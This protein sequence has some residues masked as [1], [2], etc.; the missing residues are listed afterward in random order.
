MDSIQTIDR[1]ELL[2]DIERIVLKIGTSSLTREDGSFNRGLTEDIAN[3]VAKL[4]ELGKTVIIISS[5]A[6]GIGCEE[7]KMASRPR[8][9]P[10]RQAAAAVGQNILMQEWMAAFKKHDL[11]V[12]QILLTY[13][14]FSN[15]MTYLNLRNS[16]SA[17]LEAGVVPVVNENDPI[18]VHEIEAT[19]GDN[20][21][22][23][24]M[25]ASKVEAE[26]LILLSDID[27]LYDKNPKKNED[28]RLISTIEK[29]TPEIESYGGNP[30]SMK[31]VGGMRT[32]IEAAKITSISG[33]HMVIANSAVSDAVI[34]I[35][36]GED[37]GTLFLARNGKYRNRIR[38]IILS[39]ASG[40]LM[41]DRGA[42]EAIKRS[43]GLLPSGIIEVT[44]SF[45]R[46]DII[47][48]E[49]EDGVF[50]KGITDY[51]SSEL[52]KIKGKHSDMIEKVLGYKNYDEVVRK[53]NIGLL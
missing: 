22:L 15:R 12:A 53:T 47:E 39:K 40:K 52:N 3:Q 6:I 38:W 25:V 2:R 42:E 35:M 30:T 17:L 23:S 29:I 21:K 31:G 32:K 20:D 19:F 49:S 46:G 41:V 28:A 24:A 5:G 1:K 9:I 45:D 44:G 18:C 33:C 16:I 4:R 13:E 14:A 43:M 7:L 36:Y 10:L 8:E 50:A 11:K 34:R 51:T 37:I 27:G 26:L 48:I